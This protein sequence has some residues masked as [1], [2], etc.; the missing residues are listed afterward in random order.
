MK[1]EDDIT[2]AHDILIACITGE[3]KFT[4]K[5]L[6][7]EEMQIACDVLCWILE[8]THNNTFAGNLNHIIALLETN[9]YHLS[10]ITDKPHTP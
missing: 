10:K 5:K 6:P 7:L 3:V 8:H 9:G 2:K 4:G 1:H